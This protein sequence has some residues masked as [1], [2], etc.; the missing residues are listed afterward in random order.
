MAMMASERDINPDAE[1]L[2]STM[3][4]RNRVTDATKEASTIVRLVALDRGDVL[5]IQNGRGTRVRATDGVL[6]ITEENSPDDHV[7]LP[8]RSLELA[9]T[10]LAIVLAHRPARVV[11]GV[12]PARVVELRLGRGKRGMRIALA[13]P[14]P[15]SLSLIVAGIGTVIGKVLASIDD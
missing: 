10:G 13:E 4:P 8:G 2:G 1:A 5:R 11:V 6:W 9:Q 14:T 12:T 15:I 3:T 7:L